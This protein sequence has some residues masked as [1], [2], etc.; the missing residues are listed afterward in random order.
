MRMRMHRA[1]RLCTRTASALLTHIQLCF[2][3]HWGYYSKTLAP[4]ITIKSGDSI[5]VEMLT[6]HAGAAP[7]APHT[8]ARPRVLHRLC[9]CCGTYL[10]LCFV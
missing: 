8:C 5:T 1:S 6:H 9:C 2:A 10:L 3:V 7:A 4:A